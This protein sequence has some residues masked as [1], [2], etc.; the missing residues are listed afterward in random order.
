MNIMDRVVD[1]A[2]SS[3]VRKEE[4][5]QEDYN[6]LLKDAKILKAENE[7]LKSIDTVSNSSEIDSILYEKTSSYINK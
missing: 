2:L 7:R 4:I 3:E 5:L 1:K 6:K